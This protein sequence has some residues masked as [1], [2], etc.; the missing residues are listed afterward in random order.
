HFTPSAGRVHLQPVAVELG[1][2]RCPGKRLAGL[3]LAPQPFAG[4]FPLVLADPLN[5]VVADLHVAQVLELAG[6]AVERPDRGD[7]RNY[8]AGMGGYRNRVDA[9]PV[10][11]WRLGASA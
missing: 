4:C 1:I 7:G 11:P 8:L 5:G 2:T 6:G 3:G 9:R 10:I